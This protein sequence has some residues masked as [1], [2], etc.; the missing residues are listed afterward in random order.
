[1]LHYWQ[2]IFEGM[3]ASKLNDGTPVLLSPI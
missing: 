3:K 2:S 1:V